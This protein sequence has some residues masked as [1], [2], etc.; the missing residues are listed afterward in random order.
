LTQTRDDNV[1]L[2]RRFTE[3]GKD[4]QTTTG[5]A[6]M[7]IFNRNIDYIL[8]NPR[9]LRGIIFNSVFIGLL[10]LALYWKACNFDDLPEIAKRKGPEEAKIYLQEHV[11]NILG[12]SLLMNNNLFFSSAMIVILQIPLMVPVFKRELMNKMYSPTIYFLARFFSNL[13]LQLFYPLLFI[14]CCIYGIGIELSATNILSLYGVGLLLNIQ[15]VALA[16]LAGVSRDDE[17]SARLFITF[18]AMVAMLGCGILSNLTS[19]WFV[20]LIG[21]ISPMR[22]GCEIIVRRFLDGVDKEVVDYLLDTLGYT[23]GEKICFLAL[24]AYIVVF[25]FLALIVINI[26]NRKYV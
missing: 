7:A 1:G 22:Y 10:V 17:D 25:F 5:A 23:Y 2:E 4:R 6:F 20:K 24:T 19:G 8:K 14:T 16:Y 13:L 21:Y 15:A 26:R 9:T 12:L 18:Y 3:I 11:N